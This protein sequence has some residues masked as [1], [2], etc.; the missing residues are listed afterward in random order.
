MKQLSLISNTVLNFFAF[1]S[2]IAD[3]IKDVLPQQLIL[4]QAQMVVESLC[5]FIQQSIGRPKLDH[6]R[7]LHSTIIAAFR[8]VSRWLELHPQLLDNSTFLYYLMEVLELG[9]SGR[10]SRNKNG[11]DTPKHEKVTS[12]HMVN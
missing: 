2:A 1:S 3:Y 9:I 4:E 10:K 12:G 8:C 7:E 6:R 5:Q 11:V